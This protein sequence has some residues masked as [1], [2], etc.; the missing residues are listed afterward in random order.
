MAIE[1]WGVFERLQKAGDIPASVKF[2]ISIP[3]PIAPTY[4]N[5]VPA[6]RQKLLAALVP[7]FL[8]EVAKIAK[9]LPNDRI[10]I[11]WDVCQEV[12]AWENYYDKGPV[13]FRTETIDVLT[14]IGDGVPAGIEL[15][16]HLCYGSPADEHMVL[17]K[18]MG[19]M[20]EMTNAIVAGVKRPIQFFHMPVVKARTDDA[21]FAPLK[22]LK[23]RPGTELYLGLIHHNDAGGERGAARR[24]PPSCAGGR[25]RHRM[26]HGARRSGAV[27]GAARGAP[28]GRR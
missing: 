10:A 18:D 19:I 23:L 2:Q 8:G 21:Y 13:D 24:R 22:G 5:M 12:L 9:A 6:D 26:R 16:Y 27:A 4:N 3:T 11:Q 7:H 28:A 17:P 25:H 14:R 1:S 15:G 20:V